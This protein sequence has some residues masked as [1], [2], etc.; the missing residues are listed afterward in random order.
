M[1]LC[2]VFFHYST[3]ST[4]SGPV[5]N[6]LQKKGGRTKQRFFS[7]DYFFFP[8][9]PLFPQKFFPA[10]PLLVAVEQLLLGYSGPLRVRNINLVILD[11]AASL[12]LISSGDRVAVPRVPVWPRTAALFLLAAVVKVLPGTVH[13]DGHAKRHR[14][15]IDTIRLQHRQGNAV[16]LVPGVHHF[17]C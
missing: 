6:R 12:I 7:V 10:G 3:P 2:L 11:Q 5:L 1:N 14:P 15:T 16:A 8:N 9:T 4:D 17:F 13:E